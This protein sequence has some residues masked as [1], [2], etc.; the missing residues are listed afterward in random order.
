MMDLREAMS[1]FGSGVTVVTSRWQ[2]GKP[3]GFTATAFASHSLEPPLVLVCLARTARSHPAFAACRT[4][5]VSVL[6]A[7]HE[8]VARRFASPSMDK[9][10]GM[11][12]EE[13]ELTGLPVIQG[14]VVHLECEAHA[15]YPGG[16]H[17]IIIGRVINTRINGGEPLIYHRGALGTF[18][19]PSRDGGR[20]RY[21]ERSRVGISAD[22]ARPEV[23]RAQDF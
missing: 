11:Q 18:A 17:D 3:A 2:D 13:G 9:F 19:H 12:I 22:S 20:G 10:C 7:D 16:D 1:N 5:A 4:F 23:S 15:V 8:H 6:A 21:A 14:A